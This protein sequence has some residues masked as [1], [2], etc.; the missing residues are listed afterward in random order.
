MTGLL[1]ILYRDDYLAAIDKP[2][3][4]LVH[5]TTMASDNVAALQLLCDQ[6]GQRV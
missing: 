1:P 5:R 2:S 3:G 4:L 6:L